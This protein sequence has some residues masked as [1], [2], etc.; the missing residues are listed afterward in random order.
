[1]KFFTFFIFMFLVSCAS[2]QKAVRAPSNVTGINIDGII[3][4]IPNKKSRNAMKEYSGMLGLSSYDSE[5]HKINSSNRGVAGFNLHLLDKSPCFK[6]LVTD[7]YTKVMEQEEIRSRSYSPFSNLLELHSIGL[8]TNKIVGVKSGWLWDT[9]MKLSDNSPNISMAL[10][11]I[12]GHDDR[13]QFG[14][15]CTYNPTYCTSELPFEGVKQYDRYAKSYEVYIENLF[16]NWIPKTSKQVERKQDLL[17]NSSVYKTP[18]WYEGA[19]CPMRESSM[20]VQGSMG[21]ETLLT[22][23]LVDYIASIQAPNLGTKVIPA[24]YYHVIGSAYLTCSLVRNGMPSFMIRKIH[25]TMIRTY[26]MYRVCQRVSELELLN[27]HLTDMDLNDFLRAAKLSRED[28]YDCEEK[29]EAFCKI[30]KAM[31]VSPGPTLPEEDI[32]SEKYTHL[33]N[34]VLATN[35][36]KDDVLKGK[37]CRKIQHSRKTVNKLKAISIADQ[38]STCSTSSTQCQKAK[39]ILHTWYIDFEWTE[40]QHKLGTEFAINNCRREEKFIE[41]NLEKRSCEIL[42]QR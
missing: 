14:I 34:S 27:D 24:K 31:K 9:A 6:K 20:Y 16:K 5:V 41:S 13:R 23:Q 35:I 37:K 32:L 3:E 17:N 25:S 11:G 2:K 1:M 42:E 22:D 40:A 7:F 36:F 39:H 15:D 8:D 21:E 33:L 30:T 4:W 18:Y 19:L 28:K 26:R 10:I 29:G 38:I 12:C